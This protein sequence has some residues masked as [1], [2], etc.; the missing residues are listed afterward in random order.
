MATLGI[1]CVGLITCGVGTGVPL[2]ELGGESPENHCLVPLGPKETGLR[3]E[4]LDTHGLV[5]SLALAAS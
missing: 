5:E 1:R 3:L 2:P 4:F